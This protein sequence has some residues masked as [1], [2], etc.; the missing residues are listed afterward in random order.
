MVCTSDP[1]GNNRKRKRN[2]SVERT[3]EKWKMRART[4]EA[5]L[6][7]LRVSISALESDKDEDAEEGRNMRERR[8]KR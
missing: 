2:M 1:L 7:S 4:P 3:Y 8:Q 6:K 5:S